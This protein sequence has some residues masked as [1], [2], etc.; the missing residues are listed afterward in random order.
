MRY[1]ANEPRYDGASVF[2]SPSTR[3]EPQV[4]LDYTSPQ[5]AEVREV[6]AIVV[7]SAFAKLKQHGYYDDYVAAYP[8]ELLLT[9]T[10]ALAASW[11]PIEA[12]V[13][14][15]ATMEAIG[16]NDSQIARLAEESGA[17]LFDQ[18]FATVVRAVR[19]A[20]GGSGVWFGF[21]Q[22]DRVMARIYN[23]GGCHVT[24]VGPKD[25]LYEIRGLPQVS[26]RASRISQAAFMRGVLSITT[27]VCVVKVVPPSQQRPDYIR[28]SL[29]WV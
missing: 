29:S 6:R 11:V 25:A 17:G 3:Y 8:K 26:A 13:A 4:I 7:Q 20:G 12:T 23:G 27:K 15:Y 19:N 2:A 16:L 28:L 22:A 9:T 24:Q 5:G 10:Q 18:L 14:H 1:H 21:K